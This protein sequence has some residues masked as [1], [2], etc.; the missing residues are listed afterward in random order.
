MKIEYCSNK[1]RKQ[2][3][4]ASEIKKAFGVNA[5]RVSQRMDDIAAS[6]NLAVLMQIPAANCHSLAG[7]RK[8]QWS[9][10]ISGNH[11]LIFELDGNPLPTLED[12]SVDTIKVTDIR[13]IETTDY[14]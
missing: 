12:G 3:T 14:H 1:L 13:I 4:S 10:D 5:K 7:K 8:G 6:T 9:V 11:R 2:L